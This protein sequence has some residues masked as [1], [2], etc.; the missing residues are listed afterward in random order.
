M[1]K[2]P[3]PDLASVCFVKPA[4]FERSRAH[5]DTM[6][7]SGQ[8]RPGNNSAIGVVLAHLIG[9]DP[10]WWAQV[11]SVRPDWATTP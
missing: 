3:V 4:Y 5:L 2:L 8:P 9:F 7:R 10:R 6:I 1:T 11:L